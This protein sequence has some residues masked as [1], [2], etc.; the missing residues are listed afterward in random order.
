MDEGMG[1]HS[2]RNGWQATLALVNPTATAYHLEFE[3]VTN[4]AGRTITCSFIDKDG[5]EVQNQTVAITAGSD[6]SSF[7]PY[8]VELSELP[9]GNY[10]LCLTF[11]SD[12]YNWTTNLRN[13]RITATGGETT[14]IGTLDNLT[15]SQFDNCY[16]LQGRKVSNGKLNR[17]MAKGL[18]ITSGKKVIMK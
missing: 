7:N 8:D 5:N 2:F 4:N 1:L 3:A 9:A 17:Q 15:V 13:L 12:G 10:A 16:D 11:N 14:A 6:W 18:Y